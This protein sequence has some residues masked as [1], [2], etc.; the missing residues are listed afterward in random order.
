MG[1]DVDV[2][3]NFM[4][5]GCHDPAESVSTSGR[6]IRLLA[7]LSNAGIRQ[8]AP[9][10]LK[11]MEPDDRVE[12]VVDSYLRSKSPNMRYF[13]Q[14]DFPDSYLPDLCKKYRVKAEVWSRCDEIGDSEHFIVDAD[15]N[16]LVAEDMAYPTVFDQAAEV[17]PTPE[18]KAWLDKWGTFNL[19]PDP[20]PEPAPPSNSS[21]DDLPF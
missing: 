9:M 19:A 4:A 20:K 14:K 2:K 16:I 3:M 10:E 6:I 12:C 1:L 5:E 17:Q 11:S 18:Q 21:N 15:G 7:E 8:L 13:T